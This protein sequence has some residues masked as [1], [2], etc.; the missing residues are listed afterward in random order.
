MKTTLWTIMLLCAINNISAQV[1]SQVKE[2]FEL[3]SIAFRLAGAEEYINNT[4]PGYT[5]DIDNYFSKY[6]E[7]K[8]ISYI[9]KIRE[10]QGIAYDAVPAATGCIEIKR[11]KVI[12]D[13]QCD[14]SKI[15]MI[16]SRWTE[17]SFRTFVRLLNDFYR[18]TKFKDFYT[19]HRGLYDIA[20]TRLNTILVDLNAEWFKSMFGEGP[21]NTIVVASLCNGPGNYAFNGITKGEKRGIV[22]GCSTDK[23]GNPAYSR[24]LITV[25]VHELLHHYTNPC[26]AQYWSQIDSA[27]QI[28][29]PHVKEKM[30]K[31]AYGSTNSTMIE[32]F[33]NLLTIMYFKD[34]PNRGFTA[35]HLTAWRQHE[36]FIWME[37]SM[38]F[39][40]H[41]RNHRNLYSTIKDFMPEIGQPSGIAEGLQGTRRDVKAQADILAVQSLSGF[42]TAVS[43]IQSVHM[44]GQVLGAC[45]HPLKDTGLDVAYFH[46]FNLFKCQCEYK[47]RNHERQARPVH[48]QE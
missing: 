30:A 16:D 46:N 6:R 17:E 7:H 4:I 37:R 43:L 5:A 8:L 44:C 24:F 15:S 31:L 48:W 45:Q 10:E 1:K 40:E 9:K 2:S 34:N 26:L 25:I 21:E 36:G 20:E 14:A 28:I 18:Q 38:T 11:G 39:M 3:T 35:T 19:L 23:E 32:W 27:S 42:L 13:P 12:I 47:G 33:N 41:F 22:I 29:Y